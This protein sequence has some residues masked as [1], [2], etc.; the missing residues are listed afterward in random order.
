MTTGLQFQAAYTWTRGFDYTSN[1]ENSGFNG[2]GLNPWNIAQSYGPSANDAPQRQ[3]SII[4]TPCPFI[5]WPHI[6]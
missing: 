1:F 2:P 3:S 6:A 4:Y 5:D